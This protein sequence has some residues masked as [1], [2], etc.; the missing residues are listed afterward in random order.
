MSAKAVSRLSYLDNLRIYLTVLVILRHT[1]IAYGGRTAP[2]P[3]SR[4]YS[5]R[6]PPDPALITT[7]VVPACFLLALVIRRV[8]CAKR[9][10]G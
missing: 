9:V 3:S 5:D 8:P 4:F 7:I 6:F 10:L 1:S 2:G